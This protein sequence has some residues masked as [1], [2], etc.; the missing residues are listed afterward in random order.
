M[1][2]STRAHDGRAADLADEAVAAGRRP[3][4]WGSW[5]VFEH[6]VMAMRAY[7][8]TV[9]FTA[10]GTPLCYLFA[11]GIGLGTLITG[12][13][14]PAGPSGQLSYLQFVAPALLATAGMLVASE[15]WMFGVLLGFKWNPYFTGMHATA[16]SPR[17]IVTGKFL[18]AGFRMLIVTGVY[19]V[20]VAAFGAVE[21]PTGVLMILCGLL[22]GFAFS[23]IAAYSASIRDDRGQFAILNRV[24]L[25]PLSLFSGTLFPL[26][27][28]PVAVQWIGWLSPLWHASEL[29]RQASYG[30]TEP[31]WVS[32]LRVAYLLALGVLG[33]WLTVRAGTRRLTR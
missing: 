4:R 5:Y 23:P 9:V 29:G 17:Q 2:G 11:F 1:S 26:S 33:W 18:H 15:E 30:P 14:G 6:H 7:R 13:I 22:C 24:V 25:L 3:R 21:A 27:T 20:I 16:L 8:W 28:L 12:N 32:A 19:F 31:G 10:I